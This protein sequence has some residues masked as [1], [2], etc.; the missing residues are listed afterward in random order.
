MSEIKQNETSEPRKLKKATVQVRRYTDPGTGAPCGILTSAARKTL[1]R[2][3]DIVDEW[4]YAN[5]D[6]RELGDVG[7]RTVND[8]RDILRVGAAGKNDGPEYEGKKSDPLA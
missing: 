5:R 2:A 4:A 3:A 6:E 7:A 1:A 8:L